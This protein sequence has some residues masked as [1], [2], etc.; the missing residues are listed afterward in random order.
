MSDVCEGCGEPFDG[1]V[2]VEAFEV[3]EMILCAECWDRVLDEAA[4]QYGLSDD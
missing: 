2:I 3:T 1:E 4:E